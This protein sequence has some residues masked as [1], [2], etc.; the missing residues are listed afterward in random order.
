MSSTLTLPYAFHTISNGP[1]LGKFSFRFA[2]IYSPSFV[3]AWLSYLILVNMAMKMILVMSTRSMK[4]PADLYKV[5]MVSVAV[6]SAMS[7]NS[8]RLMSAV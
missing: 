8:M 4:A 6:P 5:H 7:L 2:F 1:V 3:Y